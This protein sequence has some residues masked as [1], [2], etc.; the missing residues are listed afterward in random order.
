MLVSFAV[1]RFMLQFIFLF[2]LDLMLSH[3][4]IVSQNA[5]RTVAILARLGMKGT[6][7][8]V[9]FGDRLHSLDLCLGWFGDIPRH[10]TRCGGGWDGIP[11]GDAP[12]HVLVVVSLADDGRSGIFILEVELP[13]EAG[14]APANRLHT[15]NNTFVGI[16]FCVSSWMEF[17]IMA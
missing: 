2:L 8:L 1:V 15:M 11:T 7:G 4:H 17:H 14:G 10:E 13:Y 12:G 16:S 6:Q 5:V 3:I 9:L